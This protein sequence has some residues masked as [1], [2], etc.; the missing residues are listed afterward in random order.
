MSDT[1][2]V[3]NLHFGLNMSNYNQPQIGYTSVGIGSTA[4]YGFLQFF[5]TSNTLC[6]TAN[7]T[8]GIG[9]TNPAATLDVNGTVSTNGTLTLNNS[10]FV[11]NGTTSGYNLIIE[12]GSSVGSPY[13]SFYAAGTRRGYIG[14]ATT[15]TMEL[16]AENGTSLNFYT[17]AAHRM[18]ITTGGNVGIG[19]PTP[20]ANLDVTGSF[21]VLSNSY[22]ALT[23]GTGID[24]IYSSSGTMS[25]GTRGGG[26]ALTAAPMSYAASTHTFYTGA[27]AGTNAMTINSSGQVSISTNAS[28]YALDVTG[29]IQGQSCFQ[30]NPNINNVGLGPFQAVYLGQYGASAPRGTCIR[31]GDV[32]GAAYYIHTGSFNLTFAKDVSGG[33][34]ASALQIIGNNASNATPHVYINNSLGIRTTA[35]VGLLSVLLDGSGIIGPSTWSSSY[36]LFG[37]GANSVNGSSVGITYNTAGEYG[38]LLSRTPGVAWRSM[39]FAAAVQYFYVN[40][41][42][43]GYV[44]AGGFVSASDEREKINIKNIN[45]ERSL[46]RILSCTPK[47]FQR[48]MDR[49]DPM[50]PDEVK[51]KWHIGLNAQEV[52]SINPHC[53]S[54]WTNQDGEARYGINYTDFVTHLIGSVQELSKKITSQDELIQAQEAKMATLHGTCASLQARLDAL[55]ALVATSS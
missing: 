28:G 36:A 22:V 40:G 9:L 21:R 30:S 19:T 46:Q 8:V 48:I 5:G 16:V 41:S 1:I 14:N 34:A 53:I 32:A 24:I 12:G 55:E 43:A 29:I 2:R 47:T 6:W 52:L 42:L 27:A 18:A 4:N 15:T 45:T 44:N 31:I 49:A 39:Y 3:S 10:T 13:T 33:N 26:G 25:C 7:G 11:K 51:N 50:I 38:V 20:V 17:S 35:P 37:P 54:E 23:S